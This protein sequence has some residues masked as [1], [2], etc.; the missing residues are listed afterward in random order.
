M[1]TLTR[2]SRWLAGAVVSLSLLSAGPLT[3]DELKAQLERVFSAREFKAQTFGPA[4]WLDGGVAYTTVEPS[5]VVADAKDIVRYE[6]SGGERRVLV[7]AQDLVAAAGESPLTIDDYAWS[8]DGSRLL[9]FT[10]TVKVWRRNTR[11]DYWLLDRRSGALRQVGVG[12]PE[13]TLMFAKLSPDGTRVAYV[14]ENDLY[15]ESL[16]DGARTRADCRR[17]PDHHQRHHRLGLRGGVRSPRRLPLEPGRRG[18]RVLALRRLRHRAVSPG[19]QHRLH[20]PGGHLDPVPEGGHHQLGGE[21][22]G[23]ERLWRRSALDE[24]PG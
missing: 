21:D 8:D 6:T 9:V 17:V 5:E 20:L 22:R 1:K 23:S 12:L 24:R 15:V 18:H 16:A 19:Q 10:N 14:Q 11:G 13:S 2:I 4:R 3:A 7:S